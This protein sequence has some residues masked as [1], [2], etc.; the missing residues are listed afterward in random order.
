MAVAVETA[1]AVV[2]VLVV[3]G[4]IAMVV[5]SAGIVAVAGAP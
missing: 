5:D 3:A 4:L 1:V 2:D